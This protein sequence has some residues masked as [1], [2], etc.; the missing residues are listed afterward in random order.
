M[1]DFGS[2]PYVRGERANKRGAGPMADR[3]LY[4]EAK[5][6]QKDAVRRAQVTTWEGLIRIIEQDQWGKPDG[7]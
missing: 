7:P 1:L 6:K 4:R 2:R 3:E 5:K